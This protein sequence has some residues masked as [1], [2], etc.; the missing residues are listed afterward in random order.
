MERTAPRKVLLR[1]FLR[2]LHL[3][4]APG[5]E[6]IL[7][8]DTLRFEPTRFARMVGSKPWELPVARVRDLRLDGDVLVIHGANRTY[9]LKGHDSA[10]LHDRLQS[11]VGISRSRTIPFATDERVLL[12]G[13]VE[14]DGTSTRFLLTDERIGFGEQP[15][16][17]QVALDDVSSL[18]KD[19]DSVLIQVGSRTLRL[20]GPMAARIHLVVS[21]IL[22]P[23]PGGLV[24]APPLSEV[25]LWPAA[26]GL[27]QP[28]SD[29]VVSPR[30][31]W[32]LDGGVPSR[33]PL[34]GLLRLELSGTVTRRLVVTESGGVQR[35]LTLQSPGEAMDSL[36]LAAA[37]QLPP[38]GDPAVH[39]ERWAEVLDP[40]SPREL[41][42]FAPVFY[43]PRPGTFVRGWLAMS[44]ARLLLLPDRSQPGM[45]PIL[46]AVDS[47]RY[48][49][50]GGD[51]GPMLEMAHEHGSTRV[52]PKDGASFVE[53]FW[54][55]WGDIIR[56]SGRV[57]GPLNRRDCYRVQ[58]PDGLESTYQVSHEVEPRRERKARVADLSLT[59]CGFESNERLP[60]DCNLQMSFRYE[61]KVIDV[62]G[63]VVWRRPGGAGDSWRYGFVF[64]NLGAEVADLVRWVVMGLQEEELRRLRG[65]PPKERT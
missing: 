43:E 12:S 55:T 28:A 29:L 53:L 57:S 39:L 60:T 49:G 20:R 13:E 46:L 1:V 62:E 24:K 26:R 35:G 23:D 56:K 34:E 38:P 63:T 7:T 21:A 61:D 6:V 2:H 54:S 17:L 36:V 4:F 51:T 14:L 18:T 31:A 45:E 41:L 3:P 40:T 25:T 9:R 32:W 19:S 59:G 47:I 30:A 11:L 8:R 44:G 65:L 22:E 10:A 58:I 64:R 42:L 15:A 33:H 37:T 16:L 50:K 48:P 27:G 5:G 52:A